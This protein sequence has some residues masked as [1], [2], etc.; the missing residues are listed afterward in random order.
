MGFYPGRLRLQG[1]SPVAGKP[2]SAGVLEDLSA[3]DQV[4]GDAAEAAGY[5]HMVA[6]RVVSLGPPDLG[7]RAEVAIADKEVIG[8]P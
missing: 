8:D 4:V 5:A 1:L 6:A 2:P 3:G 7:Q